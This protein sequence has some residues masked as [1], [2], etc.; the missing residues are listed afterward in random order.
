[1]P[2]TALLVREDAS[3]SLAQCELRRR[4]RRLS[5]RGDRRHRDA[6]DVRRRAGLSRIV[7]VNVS[8]IADPKLA[9]G[10]VLNSAGADDADRAE[11]RQPDD[12]DRREVERV[13]R[14][15]VVGG[16]VDRRD[17]ADDDRSGVV[18]RHRRQVAGSGRR[19]RRRRRAGAAFAEDKRGLAMQAA[20]RRAYLDPGRR[21]RDVGDG[22]RAGR[23]ESTVVGGGQDRRQ[24]R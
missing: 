3:S 11:G 13:V 16:D 4:G 22:E 12:L 7:Y 24:R 15:A 9:A 10:F 2:A 8:L 19:G 20:E 14:V 18:V 21:G 6:R 23:V 5:V 17:R 1:M